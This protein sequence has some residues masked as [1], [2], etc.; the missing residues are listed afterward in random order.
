MPTYEYRCDNCDH[1]FEREQRITEKPLKKC[2]SCGKD[3]SR[4]MIT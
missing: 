2:P 3:K 1:E 4:R